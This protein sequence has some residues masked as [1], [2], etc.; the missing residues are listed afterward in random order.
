MLNNNKRRLQDAENRAT[1]EDKAGKELRRYW[2]AFGEIRRTGDPVLEELCELSTRSAQRHHYPVD[3]A[4]GI[5]N[6]ADTD[7]D[8]AE[9]SELK[10]RHFDLLVALM[11]RH[12]RPGVAAWLRSD[13]PATCPEAG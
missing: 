11:E 6:T 12:D 13:C 2:D 9:L 5:D 10:Q 1:E 8:A 7:A 3:A 4:L